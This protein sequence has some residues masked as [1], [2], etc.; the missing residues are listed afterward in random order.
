MTPGVALARTKL[1]SHDVNRVELVLAPYDCAIEG[2]VRDP[3]GKGCSN[4]EVNL[5]TATRSN[6]TSVVWFKRETRTDRHG[7]Y[8]FDGLPPG[9]ATVRVWL[10]EDASERIAHPARRRLKLTGGAS[11]SE[12]DFRIAEAVTISGLVERGSS[13]EVLHL[14][15]KDFETDETI[16]LQ[17]LGED[18]RFRFPDVFPREHQLVVRG[19]EQVVTRRRIPARGAKDLLIEL[20]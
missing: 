6:G 3:S 8:R 20:P 17:E 5:T 15:L 2:T 9:D 7:R 14:L 16:D 4:I 1:I 12:T 13:A 18:G 19:N 11:D 10:S